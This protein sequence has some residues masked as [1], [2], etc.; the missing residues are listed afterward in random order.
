MIEA[1]KE[2]KA[3]LQEAA[4]Q[5]RQRRLTEQ[6]ER[7]R[8]IYHHSIN[9]L[10]KKCDEQLAALWK[11]SNEHAHEQNQKVAT[12]QHRIERLES[13]HHTDALN[14][15]NLKAA[16]SK[17][18]KDHSQ[19]LRIERKVV[20]EARAT[21]TGNQALTITYLTALVEARALLAKRRI[22]LD[23]TGSVLLRVMESDYKKG[24]AVEKLQ[25]GLGK[26]QSD[27]MEMQSYME[28]HVKTLLGDIKAKD[29]SL[30]II[31]SELAV[32]EAER[33]FQLGRFDRTTLFNAF[34]DHARHILGGQSFSGEIG[35][36]LVNVCICFS[37]DT[38]EVL[39]L[40][41]RCNDD[42]YM[43]WQSKVE[44]Y[45][46]F[47]Y[48][49]RVWVR[50]SRG[51]HEHP[52]YISMDPGDKTWEWLKPLLSVWTLSEE[53]KVLLKNGRK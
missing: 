1:Q 10:E 2:E 14:I 21:L 12:K 20:Q 5:D 23:K 36:Q 28:A 35:G 39:L 48:Q 53:E 38:G 26:V 33:Q 34:S 47:T 45:T 6:Q 15:A 24:R 3:S 42:A 17:S 51:M 46:A 32:Y 43:I 49:W 19:E 37:P 30:D 44:D 11:W 27:A 41:Q 8:D 18:A 9:G 7:L 50:I 4:A 29:T 52:F 13:V 16:A 22:R 25:V 40:V 31:N